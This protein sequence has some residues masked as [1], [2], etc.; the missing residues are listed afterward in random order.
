MQGKMLSSGEPFVVMW[1]QSYFALDFMGRLLQ[2]ASM[3]D[4]SA[5]E[6]S[7][8]FSVEIVGA[9]DGFRLNLFG[10]QGYWLVGPGWFKGRVFRGKE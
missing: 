6:S 9:V 4:L 5:S 7:P 3:V 10:R 1:H 8:T 2:C